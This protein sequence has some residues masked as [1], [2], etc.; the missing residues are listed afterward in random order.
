MDFVD[1]GD[2][3]DYLDNNEQNFRNIDFE[4]NSDISSVLI[5]KLK[6]NSDNN[7]GL[8]L[9]NKRQLKYLENYLNNLRNEKLILMKYPVN[10]VI[11][12]IGCIVGNLKFFPR[13]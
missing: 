2:I 11:S 8:M 10:Q 6:C 3:F 7:V 9:F 5:E 4:D 1:N 12:G 13:Y